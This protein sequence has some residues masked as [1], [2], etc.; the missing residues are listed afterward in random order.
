METSECIVGID[1]GTTSIKVGLYNLNGRLI[2]R[3]QSSYPSEFPQ[4]GHVEQAP[5]IWWKIILTALDE[6]QS[7]IK[8]DRVRAIG[9]TSQ[10]NT[11]VFCDAEFNV[12]MPAIVWSD[13]R[14]AT[15]AAHL[16]EQITN[17][18]RM[19]WWGAPMPI[20][21]SHALSRIQ[22]AQEKKPD[23]W[24]ST[25]HV[26]LPK[27]FIIQQ[28]TGNVVSD[29]W[30]NIGL[31]DNELN[32]CDGLFNTVE[33]SLAVLPH[34][35]SM[36]DI[37]GVVQSHLPFAGVP[38]TVGTMDAWAGVLGVGVTQK[39]ESVYLSGTSEVIGIVSETI[40]PTPGVLVMPKAHH[41]R[42][43]VGP[44]QSGGASQLWLCQILNVTPETLATLAKQH[45]DSN[46]ST[47]LFLPHLQGERA[48][49]WDPNTRGVFLG[50][51]QTSDQGALACGVYEGVAYGARW[52]F[53]TLQQSSVVKPENL[54][55]GGG[56]FTNDVWNQ[57]RADILGCELRRVSVPDPGTLGAAS[58]AAVATGL[59]D[60]VQQATSHLVHFDKCYLPNLNEK[61]RLD[62]RFEL[63]KEAYLANKTLNQR[64]LAV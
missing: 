55:V 57:I 15:Q 2:H 18:Q 1:L 31:V 48:P 36:T 11:H 24:Q 29:P 54:N 49:L 58:I 44:T 8:P 60:N 43:H 50:L 5:T 12:L 9:V 14:A 23:V 25:Q 37:A 7:V 35:K 53:E 28:L 20:D 39:H 45:R 16:N 22:W 26:L 34:L 56:G 19:R 33:D 21:A 10:V 30:S 38:V 42:L 59:Y 51:D 4:P 61:T 41:I 47:P 63:F 27:D 62:Q 13:V 6:L 46:Q 40:E 3:I 52:L 17:V 64:W 32:Y